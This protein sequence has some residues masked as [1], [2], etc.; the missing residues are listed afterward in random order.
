[1]LSLSALIFVDQQRNGIPENSR[2]N[3]TKNWLPFGTEGLKGLPAA[4]SQTSF[5]DIDKTVVE[6]C[7][8]NLISVDN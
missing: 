1:M 4:A 7:G 3:P 6:V 8:S 5:K 2:R